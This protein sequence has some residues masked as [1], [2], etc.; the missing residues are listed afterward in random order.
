MLRAKTRRDSKPGIALKGAYHPP[1]VS[2][3]RIPCSPIP[4]LHREASAHG[5]CGAGARDVYTD[6]EVG[7][8]GSGLLLSRWSTKPDRTATAERGDFRI[9]P[10]SGHV[11]AP[12]QIATIGAK[13]P[14]RRRGRYRREAATLR[15]A[16]HE[17]PHTRLHVRTRIS[18]PTS[19]VLPCADCEAQIRSR[20]AAGRANT[21]S[22]PEPRCH[23]TDVLQACGR[24]PS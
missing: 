18:S 21:C 20:H 5:S 9:L 4:I 6:A 3:A 8:T 7:N 14:A 17:Q 23:S 19:R 12:A 16:H 1:V 13:R 15:P 2:V 10:S 24:S 22:L 11:S